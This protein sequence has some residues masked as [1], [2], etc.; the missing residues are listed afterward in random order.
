MG[1]NLKPLKVNPHFRTL[2]MFDDSWGSPDLKKQCM[3]LFKTDIGFLHLCVDRLHHCNVWLIGTYHKMTQYSLYLYI[4][5]QY[6]FVDTFFNHIEIMQL[7][8]P[9]GIM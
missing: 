8:R 2:Q 5:I 4:Y 1:T 9:Y 7:C 3:L 6:T